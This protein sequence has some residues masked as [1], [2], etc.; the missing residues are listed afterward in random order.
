MN[1]LFHLFTVNYIKLKINQQKPGAICLLSL[2]ANGITSPLR[3]SCFGFKQME[4]AH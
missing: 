1:D 3:N 4:K 2:E